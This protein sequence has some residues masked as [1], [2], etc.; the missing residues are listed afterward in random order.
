M[1]QRAG[2]LKEPCKLSG[3]NSIYSHE[4]GARFTVVRMKEHLIWKQTREKILSQIPLF[5]LQLNSKPNSQI[6][7]LALLEVPVQP[8]SLLSPLALR[9][10]LL[11]DFSS[12]TVQLQEDRIVFWNQFLVS[13]LHTLP[14]WEALTIVVTSEVSKNSVGSGEKLA[15]E[16]F[17]LVIR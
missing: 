12:S 1:P 13:W 9:W 15:S 17:I 3:E 2:W 14:N 4:L 6:L 7:P 16:I 11:A 5:M 10:R 8:S